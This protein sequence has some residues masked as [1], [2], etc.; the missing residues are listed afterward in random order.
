MT[1]VRNSAR[2]R[3]DSGALA[4]GVGLRQARTMDIAMAMHACGFDWLFIDLEHGSMDLDMA[5]QISVAALGAG[6]APIVRVPNGA[7]SMATRALDNGALGIVIPHVETAAEAR[8]VVAE[9]KYP[10]DGHRSIAGAMPQFGFAPPDLAAAAAALNRATLVVVMIET[11]AAVAEADAIAAV[12]GVDVLLIGTNDLA[13][14]LGVTGNYTDDRIV[15]A[16][17]TVI[18]ACRADDV[19]IERL[20][21]LDVPGPQLVPAEGAVGLKRI[22]HRFSPLV[23]CPDHTGG[24]A[25]RSSHRRTSCPETDSPRQRTCGCRGGRRVRR[26]TQVKVAR[27]RRT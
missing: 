15:A 6:I 26:L 13:A 10:P 9:L 11:A 22:A 17:R 3:L 24:I 25:G 7:Y 14:D 1:E 18:A 19:P 5:A 21:R 20:G 16:Y 2:A 8:E 27:W 12:A 23:A 4:L